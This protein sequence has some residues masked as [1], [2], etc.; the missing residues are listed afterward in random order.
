MDKVC[1][2]LIENHGIMAYFVYWIAVLVVS[3]MLHIFI[4]KPFVRLREKI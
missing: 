2:Q 1:P 4:E 3:Y